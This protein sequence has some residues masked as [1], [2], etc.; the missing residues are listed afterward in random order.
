[1]ID[2]FVA[3]IAVGLPMLAAAGMRRRPAEP[4]AAAPV[5]PA[6]QPEPAPVNVDDLDDE[7]AQP[8]RRPRR[9]ER[10]ALATIQ[11]ETI[12]AM[13]GVASAIGE[14]C[15]TF[16]NDPASGAYRLTDGDVRVLADTSRLFALAL[17]L[18][19][20]EARH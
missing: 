16:A 14:A 11:D 13:V 10:E 8:V 2:A 3:I 18:P 5:G 9:A 20:S 15:E 1:M 12:A 19:A 6:L 17:A 4:V 7:P